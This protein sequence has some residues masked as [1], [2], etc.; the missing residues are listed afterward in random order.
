MAKPFTQRSLNPCKRRSHIAANY[1]VLF[2]RASMQKRI[3]HLNKPL[4][5]ICIAAAVL[6][7]GKKSSFIMHKL[8]FFACFCLASVASNTFFNGLLLPAAAAI[9]AQVIAMGKYNPCM[10]SQTK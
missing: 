10:L 1:P 4:K 7:T 5:T 8:R 6:K 2:S 9:K 3:V